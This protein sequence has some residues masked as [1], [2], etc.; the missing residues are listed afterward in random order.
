MS[1]VFLFPGQGAQYPG[2][3]KDMYEHSETVRKLFAVA[4]AVL[5]KDMADLLFNGT[6]DDLKSTD[7]TQAA[8]SLVNI[9]AAALLR[10]QGLKPAAVLGFSVGEYAALHEAGVLDTETLFRVVAIRGE[11]ME[12]GARQADTSGGPSGM[13]AVL[14][15]SFEEVRACVEP[16]SSVFIANY[17]SPTQ[18]VLAGTAE[19]LEKAEE[20]LTEAGAMKVVRLRVSGPFHSPLLADAR[21]EFEKRIA[22]FPF[23]DPRIPL[24]SNVTARPLENASEAKKRAGEQ[25]VSMVQ[26][27]AS[28]QYL[29]DEKII[30]GKEHDIVLEVGPG[31]VLSGLWKSFYKGLRA[32]PAG[33]LGAIQ[34]LV[35]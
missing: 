34:E 3:A 32:K 33:T 28:E 19:G 4:N 21:K 23:N 15:L 17:S 8:I 27:V 9:S 14:G 16:I 20:A 7:N 1:T 25:I 11:L 35:R 12:K 18:I 2:M 29:L 22:G 24:I 30:T 26:W 6:E 13:T 10:E 31:K 5:R